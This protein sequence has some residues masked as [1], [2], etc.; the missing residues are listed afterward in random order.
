[1]QRREA[2]PKSLVYAID[3]ASKEKPRFFLA[4]PR[5]GREAVSGWELNRYGGKAN[6]PKGGILLIRN[7]KN[8]ALKRNGDA[9]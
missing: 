9:Q 1:M 4:T 8:Q 6:Y 7:Q 3:F 5:N 2:L